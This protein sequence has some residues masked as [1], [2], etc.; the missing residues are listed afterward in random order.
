MLYDDGDEETLNLREEKWEVIKKAD[1]DADGVGLC[2]VFFY[3][4]FS[5]HKLT[6]S[7]LWTGRRK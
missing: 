7:F 3:I 1:S 4:K 6:L 2:L 5:V